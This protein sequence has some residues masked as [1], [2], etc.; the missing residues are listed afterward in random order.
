MPM[1]GLGIWEVVVILAVALIVMGPRRL[2]DAA[3][4]L[5]RALREFRRATNELRYNLEEAAAE[6][7]R[8]PVADDPDT[9]SKEVTRTAQ[10][11]IG[12]TEAPLATPPDD[13]KTP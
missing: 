6:P 3:K 11:A 10:S 4:Q 5:G 1:F 12:P 8:R 9:Q 13:S 7:R 2:P